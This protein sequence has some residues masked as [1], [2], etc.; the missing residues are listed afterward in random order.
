MR[1]DMFLGR[2]LGPNEDEI[3]KMLNK[4]GASS[5]SE[6]LQE[7]IPESIRLEKTLELPDGISEYEFSKHIHLIGKENKGFDTFIGF[8]L[9]Y[10]S[11]SPRD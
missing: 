8:C 5:L 4:I 10:T 11:P 3:K 6:L 7:T 9:L 1:T 2:H